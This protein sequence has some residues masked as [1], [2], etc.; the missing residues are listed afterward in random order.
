M[1]SSLLLGFFLTLGVFYWSLNGELGFYF[2]PHSLIIV[3]LG[4]IAILIFSN[5]FHTLKNIAVS[6]LNRRPQSQNLNYYHDDI[7]SLTKNR[8]IVSKENSHPLLLYASDLWEQGVE[9]KLFVVLLSQKRNELLSKDEDVVQALKNLA[10]YPPALGMAG[11]VMG[12]VELFVNLDSNRDEIGGSLALAMTAT[13]FGLVLTNAIISPLADR[14][15]IR[16]MNNKRRILSIYEIVM[17]I[18]GNNPSAIILDEVKS[19]A[20]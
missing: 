5:S 17:L 2:Q 3:G 15:H 1:K 12:M 11:T 14:L 19:R 18:N 13:F 4:T 7:V 16:K 10:K 6:I 9:P 20:A 8:T